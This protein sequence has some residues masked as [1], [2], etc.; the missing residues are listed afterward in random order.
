MLKKTSTFVLMFLFTTS[1]VFAQSATQQVFDKA[2]KPVFENLSLEKNS[3]GT[4]PVLPHSATAV[5]IGKMWNAY[6]TQASYTN[7]IFTDPHSGL[8]AIIKRTDRTGLGSGRVVYQASDDGGANWTPQIGPANLA[9]YNF[10]RHPNIVLSNPTKDATPGSQAWVGG[11]AELGAT[12][13]WYQ[14]ASDQTIG[15]S[16]PWN[17]KIDSTYYPGDEMFINSQ[18]HIFAVL[19][20]I[21]YRAVGADTINND[22]Y[23]STNKGLTWTKAPISKK[24]DFHKDSWYGT[25]GFINKNG[26]G[27]IMVN[28]KK[29]GVDKYVFGYK[30]TTNDG[31][32]WD[33]SWTWV[34]PFTLPA[35]SGKVHELEYEVDAIVDGAGLLHF[36]GTFVDT[37][38]PAATSNTGIYR[39]WGSGTSWTAEL[40]SKVNRTSLSLPGG[41]GTRNEVEFATNWAGTVGVLKFCDTPTAAD[42]MYD[43][44]MAGAWGT[45]KT[46]R[47]ITNTPAV[48]EKFSQMS[49]WGYM[50]GPTTFR[51]DAM[52]TIFGG[53]DTNDLAEAELWYLSGNTFTLTSVDD[54]PVVIGKFELEQNFPNPFNPSTIIRYTIP[55]NGLVTLKVFDL[56]GREVTTLINEVQN[57]G[58]HTAQFSA[59]DMPTGMYLYTI[60]AGNFTSTKKMMLVK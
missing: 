9:P 46:V 52:Y 26:V 15:A 58:T 53:G 8:I 33:A 7:Q 40:V 39:V 44:F 2:H 5:L 14:F 45:A 49:A 43:V 55:E 48:R 30:S 57:A 59:Q 24:A 22:L 20:L 12:W 29:P 17:Q 4:N 60:T 51:A 19:P 31:A 34:D 11:W 41:L 47:N 28:G 27:Y 25:K 3:P 6:T 54:N 36:A 10:G 13:F 35:L 50:T 37:V 16:G 38:N 23:K 42:T 56:L 1:L 32:T 18:G 21:D